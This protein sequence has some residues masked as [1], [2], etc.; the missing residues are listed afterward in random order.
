M[1]S[2]EEIAQQLY[3]LFAAQGLDIHEKHIMLMEPLVYGGQS[4]SD[5][6]THLQ[7]QLESLAS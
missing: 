7:S 4:F 1:V 3:A 2:R 6:Q 5:H